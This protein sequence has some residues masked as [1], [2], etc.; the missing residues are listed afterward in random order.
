MV[1]IMEITIKV[2]MKEIIIVKIITIMMT[3]MILVVV[4]TNMIV[5]VIMTIRLIII[6][7]H[8]GQ[9]HPL[10]IIMIMSRI[11]TRH[12]TKEMIVIDVVLTK[13]ATIV[14]LHQRIKMFIY[15]PI[16]IRKGMN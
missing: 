13:K 15:Q 1:N 16:Q 8:M 9:L 14:I 3:N 10:N 5:I 12:S 7:N 4:I 11:M 6:I 2:I